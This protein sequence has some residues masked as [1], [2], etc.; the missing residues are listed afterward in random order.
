[1]TDVSGAKKSLL[2]FL[3]GR[4]GEP[5]RLWIVAASLLVVI[6]GFRSCA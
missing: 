2:S 5:S 3:K 1:M 6:V 4:E